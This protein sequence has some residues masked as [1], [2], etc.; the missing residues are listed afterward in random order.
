[1]LTILTLV[2]VLFFS[3]PAE[4]ESLA[5]EPV[6]AEPL[7]AEIPAAELVHSIRGQ[8]PGDGFGLSVVRLPD[9]DGDGVAELAVGAPARGLVRIVS[10]RTGEVRH[11]LRGSSGFGALLAVSDVNGDG[12]LDLLA[13]PV[14][15][16]RQLYRVN[17]GDD[18]RDLAP[19]RRADS[20][21]ALE[22]FDPAGDRRLVPL[23]DL[24]GDG[25]DDWAAASPLGAA[26]PHVELRSG[27]DGRLLRSLTGQGAPNAFGWSVADAGDVDGDGYADVIVGAPGDDR[28]GLDAGAAWVHS[29][30]T[31][32]TL[33]ALEGERGGERL[34]SLVGSLGD[35]DGDGHDEVWVTAFEDAGQG[36]GLGVVRVFRARISP[37]P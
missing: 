15:G 11:T 32:E 27:L 21:G 28:A 20:A 34:G 37:Q 2:P 33:L 5:P 35:V 14:A 7:V 31:G 3:A 6:L 16:D 1:M 9:R 30:R 10:G 23:G 24:D 17:D 4:A 18:G 22:M 8:T 25:L 26:D 36:P 29:G 13:G 12:S 19:V